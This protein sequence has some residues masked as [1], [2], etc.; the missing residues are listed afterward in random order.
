M[1][2][3]P[4]SAPALLG[5]GLLAVSASCALLQQVVQ[6][7]TATFRDA[8]FVAADWDSLRADLHFD[9]HN[10]NSVGLKL[11]GYAMKFAV[12]GLTLLD[13]EVAQELDMRGGATTDL[14]L[15]VKIRWAELASK[16][17]GEGGSTPG[18]LPY[19]A[20][21]ELHFNTPIGPMEI[22]FSKRG[23]IPVIKPPSVVPAGIRVRSASLTSV[24]LAVDFDISN[25]AAK[26]MSLAG[27]DHGLSLNGVNVLNGGLD[28]QVR[29]AGGKASRQSL[30]VDLSLA[31]VA[32][33]LG[34]VIM[35]G[36]ALEVAL[37]GGAQ[38]DT[39]YG[40]I[41]WSY[42]AKKSLTLVR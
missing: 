8:K 38:V 16:I 23:E 25:T 35:R 32:G 6:A 36:G 19:S 37:A 3:L 17:L 1:M 24:K 22:P 11:D 41:P 10:P 20:A 42:D 27:F 28:K 26:A 31:R 30:L 12:D 18:K 2:K 7:P 21:G 33:A 4:R 15:P 39:G 5:L 9:L 40:K 34:S 13:G 14:V 29:V